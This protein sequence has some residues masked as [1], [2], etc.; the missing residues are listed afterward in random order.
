[1]WLRLQTLWRDFWRCF[2]KQPEIQ[3]TI[4]LKQSEYK[5]PELVEIELSTVTSEYPRTKSDNM[6]TEN[7]AT[8]NLRISIPRELGQSV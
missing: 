1:M 4:L 3:S 2:Q 7:Q 6:K 5:Q 8:K